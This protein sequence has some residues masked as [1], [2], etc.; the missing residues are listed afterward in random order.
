MSTFAQNKSTGDS[1]PA[2]VKQE[3]NWN[4]NETENQQNLP[5]TTIVD[6]VTYSAN[7]EGIFITL[8]K[9]TNSIKLFTL[10]GEVFWSG[11]LVQGRFF[12]PTRRG[13]YFLRINNKSYKV[14]CK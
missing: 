2:V 4:K 6:G 9:A 3:N 8:P 5:T 11:D 7:T 13:I 1:R 14:V 12:I 10:T